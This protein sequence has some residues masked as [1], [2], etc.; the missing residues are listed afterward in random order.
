[1]KF[2]DAMVV[3]E[4]MK[5]ELGLPLLETME[6]ILD[7]PHEFSASTRIAHRVVFNEMAKLFAPLEN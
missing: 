6:Y 3:V 2:Q 4:E 7:N 5:Q 1:M